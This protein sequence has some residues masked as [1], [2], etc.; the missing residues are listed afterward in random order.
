MNEM[1]PNKIYYTAKRQPI[2]NTFTIYKT[3][4]IM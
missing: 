4:K 3:G 2:I 1:A